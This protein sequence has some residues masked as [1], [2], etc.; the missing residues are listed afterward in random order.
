MDN[1]SYLCTNSY[2][3]NQFLTSLSEGIGLVKMTKP[4]MT[5]TNISKKFCR[6]LKRSLWYGA[7]DIIGELTFTRENTAKL[8][9]KEFWS[10]NDV[11]FEL[12]KGETLGLVG[13]NGAGKSTLLKLLIGF[14]YP[15]I[16]QINI[17]GR[18]GALIELGAGFNPMLTG[19]E[20]IYINASVLGMR[21]KDVD[22]RF[23][24]IL[25]FADIGDFI[26]SPVRNYSSG[27]KVR[28]GF[29]VATHLEP[30]IL[31]IDEILAVGDSSFRERCYQRLIEHKEN[32]GSVIFV[33]H[34]SLAVEAI[35]D[36]VMVLEN[37]LMVE[38]G[39][40]S[41]TLLK[42]E[43]SMS[44]LAHRSSSK[45]TGPGNVLSVGSHANA[46]HIR[47]KST[48]FLNESGEVKSEFDYNESFEMKVKYE[49]VKEIPKA[50]FIFAI[51]K[52]SSKNPPVTSMHTMWDAVEAK[53]LPS[54]GYVSCNINSPTLTP[55]TY[56]LNV[57]ILSEKAGVPGQKWH[58]R[59]IDVGTF[60]IG[61]DDIHSKF[62][63]IPATHAVS[64][65][66]PS[67]MNHSWEIPT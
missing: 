7:K 44:E 20:N 54:N 4:V 18:V 12:A 67:M 1:L 34:N 40:P 11:S 13:H 25:D 51:H 66:P 29:S 26:D 47:I 56:I 19:R 35:S 41:K 52:G 36:K 33:S 15:D 8:R 58:C 48:D 30:D 27:M 57:G 32:G 65:M 24:E 3:E 10:L 49:S 55:G 63:G 2:R 43:Q 61:I 9:K 23:R 45:N 60:K 42:Y 37:G 28:L 14:Y 31:L 17:R 16:G 5:C 21:K 59:P 6:D 39:T 53:H 38:N 62:P 64:K 46:S 50:Y 22:Q